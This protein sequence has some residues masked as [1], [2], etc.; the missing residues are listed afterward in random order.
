[1]VVDDGTLAE[2]IAE[3]LRAHLAARADT[4][5]GPV[6]AVSLFVENVGHAYLGVSIATETRHR[7]RLQAPG[8][9]RL[10]QDWIAGPAGP[11]WD[12]GDWA[13]VCEDFT[14]AVT[15]SALEPLRTL[16]RDDANEFGDD[17]VF[18]ANRRW[19]HVALDAFALVDPLAG[20]DTTPEAIA[21]VEF[22][23]S[24][25]VEK[26]EAM[27]WSVGADRLHAAVPHWRRLAAAV[28]G[29]Q[30]DAE[31]RRHLRETAPPAE[32]FWHRTPNA[33][34][35]VADPLFL[36]LRACGLAWQDVADGSPKLNQA[37]AIGEATGDDRGPGITL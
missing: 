35:P 8:Y 1:V 34:E 23:D 28:R 5:D 36:L 37:L 14:S 9:R 26:A 3:D 33:G 18:D 4:L 13:V 7:H 15:E 31:R 10:D 19:G 29:V 25:T 24:T 27:Q 11:R 21:F 16:T 22:P 17:V 12:T 2:L 20:L 30:A 32:F 6:Y